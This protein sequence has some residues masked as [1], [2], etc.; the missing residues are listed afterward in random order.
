ME[1]WINKRFET[2]YSETDLNEIK[3]F[4]L[5]WN[6]YENIIFNTRFTLEKLEFDISEKHFDFD[7]FKGC[8]DY[9]KNRYIKDND[10][11]E[12]F[13]RLKFRQNDRE[14][15]VKTT[16]LKPESNNNDKILS[17][18]IIIYRLRNNLFHG[19]K[20]FKKFDGQVENF[21]YSNEFIQKYLEV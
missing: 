17:I 18:G 1:N 12:T 11:N 8:F 10:T 20:D 14:E 7:L 21:I 19:I 2:T 9:F 16:L 5:L 6:I 13:S 3:N 15:F 4:T